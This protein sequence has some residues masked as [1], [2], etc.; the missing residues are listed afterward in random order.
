MEAPAPYKT[1]GIVNLVCG[2]FNLLYCLTMVLSLIWV[3]VG[4]WWLIPAAAS[5]YQAFVGWQMYNGEA[6]PASK[7]GTIAGIAG[8]LLSFNLLC[9]AGSAFAFMQLGND[10]VKG[11]LEQHGAA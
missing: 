8:G 7:N 6:S 11:W 4:V 5:G 1:A 2:A 10:E 3:C 9:A